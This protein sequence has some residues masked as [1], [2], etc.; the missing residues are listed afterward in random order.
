MVSPWFA[1][2]AGFVIAAGAFI[3]APHA[4]LSFNNGATNT[5][6]CS[7]AG[8]TVPQQEPTM[9]GGASGLV[10]PSPS[11]S[12]SA[13]RGRHHAHDVGDAPDFAFSVSP[14]GPGLFQMTFT[15]RSRQPLGD[16]RLSF[17]IPG[18]TDLSV[19]DANWAPSGTDGGTASGSV[20]GGSAQGPPDSA[21]GDSAGSGQSDVV[22]FVVDGKGQPTVAPDHCSFDGSPCQFSQH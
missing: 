21:G 5:T 14:N 22:S 6:R 17:D 4:S 16:W 11:P 10:T 15:M 19:T 20:L 2:G 13:P 7:V 1:A 8:C 9:A 18:A 3:Y 12:S